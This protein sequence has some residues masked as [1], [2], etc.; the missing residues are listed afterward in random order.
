MESDW[1][2]KTVIY[3]KKLIQKN[4][5]ERQKQAPSVRSRQLD[6]NDELYTPPKINKKISVLIKQSRCLK[7]LKQKDLAKKINEPL[8]TVAD[9][10]NGTVVPSNYVLGKIEKILSVKLRGA[11]GSKN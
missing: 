7:N 9:Y 1:D 3:N 2:K 11:K 6:S 5:H 4:R 8:K 10:E